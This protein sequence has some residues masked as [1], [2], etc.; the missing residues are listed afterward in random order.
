MFVKGNRRVGTSVHALSTNLPYQN[1][2]DLYIY[3]TKHILIYLS[4]FLSIRLFSILACAHFIFV[5]LPGKSLHQCAMCNV[6]CHSPQST[7]VLTIVASMVPWRIPLISTAC[8]HGPLEDPPSR[9]CTKPS[10]RNQMR[11]ISLS[12]SLSF[13]IYIY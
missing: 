10:Q 2:K 13:Y 12:L 6:Q 5:R 7:T 3:K 1:Q 8:L 4:P 11:H 9:R